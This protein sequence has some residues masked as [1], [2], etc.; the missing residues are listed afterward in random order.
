MEEFPEELPGAG[1]TIGP[2]ELHGTSYTFHGLEDGVWVIDGLVGIR[3]EIR[4]EDDGTLSLLRTD[5]KTSNA[6]TGDNWEEL[7]AQYF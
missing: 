4:T 2:I 6:G 3:T 1:T 5:G 7:S